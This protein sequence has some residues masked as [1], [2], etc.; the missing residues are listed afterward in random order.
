[1]I[2]EHSAELLLERLDLH[3]SEMNRRHPQRADLSRG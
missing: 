3:R 1:L 2:V